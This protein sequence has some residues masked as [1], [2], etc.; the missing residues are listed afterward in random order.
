MAER[1]ARRRQT[2]KAR[3]EAIRVDSFLADYIKHKHNNLYNE[4]K[5]FYDM[6][7]HRYP[8]KLDL[9]KTKEYGFWK[10]NTGINLTATMS[11]AQLETLQTPP[12]SS[13]QTQAV[14]SDFE[15]PSPQSSDQPQSVPPTP[16]QSSPSDSEQPTSPSDEQTHSVHPD[17]CD[18]NDNL[19]LRIPLM[20]VTSI[21]KEP[22]I[23]TETL[24]TVTEETLAVGAIQPSLEQEISPG[25][26]E[27]I[28][29]ELQGDPEL[30]NIFSTLEE[31][32]DFEQLGMD[33][34]INDDNLLEKELLYW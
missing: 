7:R 30:H 12:Q 26:L 19:Q 23:I 6:L 24:E 17:Q 25:L 27:Q 8:S 3:S 2:R 20:K 34:E 10:N 22:T 14:S 9:K 5:Q 31:Q 18:Y 11:N 1:S 16:E 33:I 29:E 13:K 28:I 21:Q 4:A 15:Q 32:I